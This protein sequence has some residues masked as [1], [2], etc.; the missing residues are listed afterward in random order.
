MKSIEILEA[1]VRRCNVRGNVFYFAGCYE[2]TEEMVEAVWGKHLM[3]SINN[4]LKGEKVLVTYSPLSDLDEKAPLADVI[5][6]VL[7]GEN[8]SVRYIYNLVD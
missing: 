6:A 3:L 8:L 1:I 2:S 5:V 7:E 4:A